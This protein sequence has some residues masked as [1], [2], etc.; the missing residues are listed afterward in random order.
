LKKD[1][2]IMTEPSASNAL[3]A[4]KDAYDATKSYDPEAERAASKAEAER[5]K[6]ALMTPIERL[7][8]KEGLD[9]VISVLKTNG[10]KVNQ[11]THLEKKYG[12]KSFLNWVLDQWVLEKEVPV[13]TVTIEQERTSGD[14]AES[15]FI[16]ELTIS[17]PEEDV[18]AIQLKTGKHD[19]L[20]DHKTLSEALGR[21]GK[22]LATRN[23]P[24][25]FA[26]APSPADHT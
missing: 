20:S 12:R 10:Y 15:I 4:L 21:L 16:A 17:A 2:S 7:V 19:P 3:T 18:F 24:L 26:V 8:R 5:H 11:E 13:L 6:L 22:V 1:E 14:R 25:D 23:K 9:Q